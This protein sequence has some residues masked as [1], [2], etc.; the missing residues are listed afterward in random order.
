MLYSRRLR[1]FLELHQTCMHVRIQKCADPTVSQE[2][3]GQ[4]DILIAGGGSEVFWGNFNL[5]GV[6]T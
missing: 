5:W 6:C 3:G 4:W 1:H 2:R